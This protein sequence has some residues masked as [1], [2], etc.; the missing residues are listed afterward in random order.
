MPADIWGQAGLTWPD[1]PQRLDLERSCLI[2]LGQSL[3]RFPAAKWRPWALCGRAGAG[4]K[5]SVPLPELASQRLSSLGIE[6]PHWVDEVA[7]LLSLLPLLEA[8]GFS[9]IRRFR[10]SVSELAWGPG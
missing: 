10:R 3:L 9:K 7:S 1:R 4:E 5:P 2:H 8:F 6:R